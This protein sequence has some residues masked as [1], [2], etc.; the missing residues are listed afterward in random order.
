MGDLESKIL[1]K[2]EYKN[3]KINQIELDV[4]NTLKNTR[5]ILNK[6]IKFPFI[7]LDNDN[8]KIYPGH[9][10]S[11]KLRDILDGKYLYIKKELKPRIMLG[12]KIDSNNELCIYLYPKINFSIHQKKNS[13]NILIIGET[14]VGKSTWIHSLLNHLEKVDIDENF[15]Y[16]LFDE[17][18][19]QIEYEIKYGKKNKG[20]SVTDKP[21]VY[22]IPPTEAYPWPLRII[23][24]CG[25]GD[26]RGIEFD[27]KFIKDMKNLFDNSEIYDLKAICLIFKATD[28]K[29]HSRA[30][31][32]IN[33][34][35]SFFSDDFLK[36][37]IIIF[38]FADSL[39][40]IPAINVLK[41]NLSFVQIFEDI[42]NYPKFI[43]N[44]IAYFID[45]RIN[46]DSVFN[47]NTRNFNHFL[48]YL[49]ELEPISL[50]NTKVIMNFRIK[51]ENESKKIKGKIEEINKEI[52]N[53]VETKKYLDFNK[54]L[55]LDYYNRP[56]SLYCK[57]H[58]RICE[59]NYN[60]NRICEKNYY[61]DNRICENNY[62]GG[63]KPVFAGFRGLRRSGERQCGKSKVRQCDI[64][65]CS[66]LDHEV[67]GNYDDYLEKK[68]NK[69]NFKNIE[70]W[71]EKFRISNN[72]IF[73]FLM[74]YFETFKILIE[75]NKEINKISLL[76]QN[77]NSEKEYFSKI[78]N[79]IINDN[80]K[81]ANFLKN[82]FQILDT[83]SEDKIENIINK[84]INSLICNE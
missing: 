78:L 81:L 48:Q 5:K 1:V 52:Q 73:H 22:N 69:D 49:K 72:K 70:L 13:E 19:M 55:I 37:F 29:M 67:I 61:N 65:K 32:I 36:N 27:N 7:Y 57:R 6:Y 25:F 40:N 62:Y 30:D 44:N 71:N 31:Y 20:C 66:R 9:E 34:L 54:K 43:F 64:C 50:E 10:P 47:D 53:L 15:R 3:K 24:T 21:E 17:K 63:G 42:E 8:N 79:E 76:K 26:T 4:N 2:I 41:G 51:I 56:N 46:Y 18:K 82:N 12:E 23:D 68:K 35:L 11:I 16:V 84:F 80:N 74:N 77:K 58:N 39:T 28:T 83:Y 75:K 59:K 33:K 45:D 60:D 38:T 14:G